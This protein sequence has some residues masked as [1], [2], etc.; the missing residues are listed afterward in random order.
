[1]CCADPMEWRLFPSIV[2]DLTCGQGINASWVLIWFFYSE[3]QIYRPPRACPFLFFA[4]QPIV[5]HDLW[6]IYEMRGCWRRLCAGSQR[7]LAGTIQMPVRSGNL[8]E[9]RR[10]D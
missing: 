9:D 10:G 3:H 5:F 2:V 7:R 6:S 8:R 4:V 1:M